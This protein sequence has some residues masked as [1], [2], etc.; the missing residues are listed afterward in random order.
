[1]ET[2]V[3]QLSFISSYSPIADDEHGHFA[4]APEY[5]GMLAF[6]QGCRGERVATHYE[7][8]AMDLTAYATVDATGA[9]TAVIVNKEVSTDAEVR[10]AAGPNTGRAHVMR[11]TAPSLDSKT[12]VKLG[13]AAVASDGRWHGRYEPG[14]VVGGVCRVDVPAG[15]AAIV[16][17]GV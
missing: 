10:I 7:P 1:M 6:A 15:S 17:L 4:A 2:G 13:G 11:L 12:D 3:N 5:Y 9:P 16:M 8:G 14:H